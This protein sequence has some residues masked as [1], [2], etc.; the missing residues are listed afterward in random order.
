[1]DKEM[2]TIEKNETW[3][4]TD[5][6]KGHKLIGVKWVYKKKMTPQGTIE[7]H[8]MRLVVKGHR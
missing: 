4:M 5:L 2:K 8:K 6:P 1:M 3:E 7:R